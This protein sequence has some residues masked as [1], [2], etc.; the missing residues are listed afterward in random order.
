M[1]YLKVAQDL[2]TY[3]ITYFEVKNK[4]GSQLYLGLDSLGINIYARDN[5]LNPEVRVFFPHFVLGKYLLRDS[6]FLKYC[7]SF[8]L[9][10]YKLMN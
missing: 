5:K 9:K 2:E 1:E 3:G 10:C 4:K 6:M 7:L 8:F